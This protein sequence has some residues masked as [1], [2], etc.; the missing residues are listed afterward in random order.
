MFTGR[1]SF[2]GSG[3]SKG[4][5]TPTGTVVD[6]SGGWW[7]AGD[8]LK[9]VQTT[10]YA[11]ALMLVGIRDFPHQ[12][13]SDS[14][15]SNFVKE[16]NFGLDWLQRMWNDDSAALYYQVGI[17]SGNFG[18][19]N[20]HSIWRLPQ[21]DDSFGDTQSKYR[22]I[23]HRPVLI[24]APAGSKISPNLSGRLAAD[25]ALCFTVYRTSD[26]AYAK[27]TFPR[28]I[29]HQVANLLGSHNPPTPILAGALVEG[30]IEKADSGAPRGVKACPPNGE[31]A[32]SQFDG[33]GAMY[34]DNVESYSTAEPAIDLT[35]PSFL[36]F[37]WRI[38][39]KPA[40]LQLVAGEVPFISK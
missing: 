40:E 35:A 23:R 28:C 1:Q 14:S 9:F 36:M 13:G 6:A 19:E 34:R 29:H 39:G 11:E 32:F 31:D 22:Y 12:M 21:E 33:N 10:S 8:Y 26:P 7:D 25:F 4:D 16:A 27:S 18:F 30:P 37:A 2:P 24:A 38:V 5:L 3:A 15:I 17:G 20:D